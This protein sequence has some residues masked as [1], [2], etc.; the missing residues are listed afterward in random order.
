MVLAEADIARLGGKE[1]VVLLPQ[2]A[3]EAACAI[4]ERVRAAIAG[5][6]FEVGLGRLIEVTVS[7]GVLR[8]GRDGDTIDAM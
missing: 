7:D 3:L 1:F 2:S 4:G 6:A 8:F 5:S